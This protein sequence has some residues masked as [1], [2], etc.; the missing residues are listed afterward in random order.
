LLVCP[1]RHSS[2]ASD[3]VREN[4]DVEV[5]FAGSIELG[6]EDA[7][8][9]AEGEFAILDEDELRSAD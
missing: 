6:E 3:S 9:A 5:A 2:L 7:L 4:F 1:N 8:P